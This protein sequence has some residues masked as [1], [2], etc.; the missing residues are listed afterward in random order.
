MSER[1]PEEKP[2]PAIWCVPDELWGK[3]EPILAKSTTRPRGPGAPAP[4]G[5]PC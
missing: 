5:E 1:S 3:I 4:I 2:M